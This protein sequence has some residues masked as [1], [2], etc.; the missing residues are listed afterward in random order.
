MPGII[1]PKSSA[2]YFQTYTYRKG[3]IREFRIENFYIKYQRLLILKYMTKSEIIFFLSDVS[4]L[5]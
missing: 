1:L 5:N 4:V 3:I 2:P